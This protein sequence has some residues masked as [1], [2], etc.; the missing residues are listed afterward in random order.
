MPALAAVAFDIIGTTFALDAMRPALDRL[1]LPPRALEFIY[2]ATLRDSF[3]LACTSRY[4]PF[5]AVMAGALD[6]ALAIEGLTPPTQARAAALEGLAALE[7]YPDAGAS[8][9]ALR[10]AGLRVVALSNGSEAATRKLLERNALAA[11][12][13]DVLSVEDVKLSKPRPEVY[14]YAARSLGLEPAALALVATHPWDVHGAM[15]AGLRGGYVARGRPWPDCFAAPDVT[16]ETLAEVARALI[17][18][19]SAPRARLG[20]RSGHDTM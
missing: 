19:G 20:T 9:R 18:G 6:E 12:C 11:L 16:G 15:A 4:V 1:G 7:A 5:K 10:D 14:L 3:A 13:T 2:T 8:F 17:E